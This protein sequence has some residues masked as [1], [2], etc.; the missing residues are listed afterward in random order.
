MFLLSFLL[1]PANCSFWSQK[2]KRVSFAF[3][4]NTPVLVAQKKKKFIPLFRF[5]NT[6]KNIL[7]FISDDW[8]SLLWKK[9]RSILIYLFYTRYSSIKEDATLSV[10]SKLQRSQKTVPSATT[11]TITTK[12]PPLCS[13]FAMTWRPTG[14]V[15]YFQSPCLRT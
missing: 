1:F 14:I 6:L 5:E 9:C 8:N 13:L 15:L 10:V 4:R 2:S 7:E 3:F 11:T 12:I